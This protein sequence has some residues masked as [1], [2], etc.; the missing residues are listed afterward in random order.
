MLT[1]QNNF[2]I[3]PEHLDRQALISQFF[4]SCHMFSLAR[5]FMRWLRIILRYFTVMFIR[6]LFS[7]CDGQVIKNR[8]HLIIR[9]ISFKR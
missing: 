2:K 6:R 5:L 7:L 8:Y 4:S 3:R 1:R 9:L